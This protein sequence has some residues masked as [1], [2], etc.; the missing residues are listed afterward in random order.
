MGPRNTIWITIL[1]AGLLSSGCERTAPPANS[2]ETADQNAPATQPTDSEM[3]ALK[4][5][6]ADSAAPQSPALPPGHPPIGGT[7]AVSDARNPDAAVPQL[8]YNAPDT[9]QQEPVASPMRKGQY[10]LPAPEE[11]VAD[12]ELTVFY[13]GPG[14]GGTVQANIDRWHGQFKTEAG[15]P[16]PSSDVN[17]QEISV[18]GLTITFLELSGQFQPGAMRMADTPPPPKDDYYLLAAIVET[19]TGPWYFKAVGPTT[20]LQHHR[21]EF[22]G[23]LQSMHMTQ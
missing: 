1:T 15:E 3:S 18:N 12:A 23:F 5:F 13:F 20:T 6:V 8:A 2:P 4:E 16:V 19:P 17:Q 11:G 21:A 7:N 14:G 22:L 9:W 10:R